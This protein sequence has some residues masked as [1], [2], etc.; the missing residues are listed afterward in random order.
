MPEAIPTPEADVAKRSSAIHAVV[1]MPIRQPRLRDQVYASLR[2][3]IRNGWFPADG[4]VEQDLAAQL[5]VSRTPLREALFQLCR[6]GMLEDSGRGYRLPELSPKDVSEIIEFRLMIEPAA[7]A[8]AVSRADKAALQ[9]L[10]REFGNEKKAHKANN[11]E[12]FVLSNGNFRTELLK[13]C[14]N[15]RILQIL[16]GLDDQIRRLRAR[17]LDVAENRETTLQHHDRMLQAFKSG[18]EKA[19]NSAM[20]DLLVL[21]QKYYATIW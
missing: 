10:A 3:M 14:G 8:L 2:E 6:E 5:N 13:A 11:V 12:A 18:D 15:S 16:S 9:A 1:A 21:A 17:T 4:V 20:R 7:A 19:A